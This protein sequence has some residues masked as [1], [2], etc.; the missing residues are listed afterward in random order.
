VAGIEQARGDLDA[1]LAKHEESLAIRRELAEELGTPESRSDVAASLYEVA[2]IE[3]ARGDLD[4]AL[5][6]YDKV[7][8]ITRELAEELGTPQSRRDVSVSLD[9]VAG[10]EQARGDLDAA[11]AKYEES[12]AIAR[13]LFAANAGVNE[14]NGVLWT[15]CLIAKLELAAN[16]PQN[17]WDSLRGLEAAYGAMKVEALGDVS[18]LDTAATYHEVRAQAAEALGN[19]NT[20]QEERAK[21]AEIRARI[22]RS[23]KSGGN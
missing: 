16:R 10:I 15:S 6:K 23:K 18:C 1:A 3:Q 2:G 17:A 14:G 4:A 11:M 22:E 20:A 12:L 8:A 21:G 9:K 5:A 19:R 13:E 7:L